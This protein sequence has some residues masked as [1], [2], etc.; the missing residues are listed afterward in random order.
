VKEIY[1][2]SQGCWRSGEGEGEVLKREREKK[3]EEGT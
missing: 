3:Q 2:D 1:V